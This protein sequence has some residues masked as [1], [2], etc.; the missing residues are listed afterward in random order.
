MDKNELHYLIYT[1]FWCIH[2]RSITIK[3]WIKLFIGYHVHGGTNVMFVFR[4][5]KYYSNKSGLRKKYWLHRY[6]RCSERYLCDIPLELQVGKGFAL[7]HANGIVLNGK[8]AI[9]DNVTVLQQVTIG[10]G[11]SHDGNKVAV[12]GNNVTLGAGAK[13]IGAV[14]IGDFAFVGAN[15]VVTHDVPAGA[16]VGGGTCKDNS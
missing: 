1:D 7:F 8:A 12:I 15:A 5:C 11:N 6:I 14:E 4:H 16:V 9:G 13:V 3:D 2:H 10:N